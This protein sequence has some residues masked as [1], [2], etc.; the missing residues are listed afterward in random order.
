MKNN[1]CQKLAVA[2]RQIT[3][4]IVLLREIA[5]DFKHS[6]QR[7]DLPKIKEDA[8]NLFNELVAVSESERGAEIKIKSFSK[9]FFFRDA[10]G[11]EKALR[12]MID[13]NR[14]QIIDAWPADL[15]SSILEILRTIDFDQMIKDLIPALSGSGHTLWYVTT[16]F[17]S[18]W[19][20][21]KELMKPKSFIGRSAE[22]VLACYTNHANNFSL[23]A[24]VHIIQNKNGPAK[25]LVIFGI[26]NTD[27]EALARAGNCQYCN[28]RG[29][30]KCNYS[31]IFQ[32]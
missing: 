19:P 28:D 9:L 4:K 6:P 7:N 31:R 27:P 18:G 12:A 8:I 24:D 29:C 11:I 20:K 3:D 32:Q 22:S 16:A 26:K 5:R 23:W 10:V 15:P 1:D 30:W 13:K 21:N 14:L 2:Y 25:F 17:P